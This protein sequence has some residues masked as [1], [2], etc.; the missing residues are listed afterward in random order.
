M[1]EGPTAFAGRTYNGKPE[2]RLEAVIQVSSECVF[3]LAAG[4][5]HW[6][7]AA[8]TPHHSCTYKPTTHNTQ[9][10][11]D[12]HTNT[13]DTQCTHH[14]HTT[15]SHPDVDTIMGTMTPAIRLAA[16]VAMGSA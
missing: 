6:H 9:S 7:L 1:F 15:Q 3:L 2:D 11:P 12:G 16:A 10:H 14:T 4:Q 5:L 13:Q 8:C